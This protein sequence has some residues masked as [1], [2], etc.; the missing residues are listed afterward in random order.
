MTQMFLLP[1]AYLYY[2]VLTPEAREK[3]ITV[4]LATGR[5]HRAALDDT[6]T[7]GA[8]PNDWSRAGRI[9]LL[10][11]V[12]VA[13]VPETENHVLMI[14]TARYLTNQLLYPRFLGKTIGPGV[15]LW[16]FY[17]NR[18]NGNV[19]DSV[20]TCMDQV[21]YLLRNKLRD[22][23]AE[24]NA[25]PYQEETR[26]ALLNLFSYAY[27]AEVRLAA[28]MVL[29]YVSAHIAVSS[30]DLR[31]M[32]P[33]RRRNEDP[34]QRQDSADPGFMDIDLLDAHGADPMPAHFAV[35]AQVTPER[36]GAE[37]PHLCWRPPGY[38]GHTRQDGTW[39]P[40]PEPWRRCA[41][42]AHAD[43]RQSR[44]HVQHQR[45]PWLDP[46]LAGLG[47][48][49]TRERHILRRSRRN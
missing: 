8:A 21:L 41:H 27:D 47:D 22:D 23:F 31:R 10:G 28:G 17:D 38:L 6:L 3:L 34:N 49:C 43:R 29:D 9:K 26:W 40:R 36:T 19:D 25:K 48:S 20:P 45:L 13:D 4:L 14:A 39:L 12:K 5:I 33:F 2:D 24:Y 30:S 32:V 11:V 37:L 35:H 7:S 1:L 42:L 15:P 16:P 18:R 46:D 44:R